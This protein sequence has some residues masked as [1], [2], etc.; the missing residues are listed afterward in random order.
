M[1]SA[2]YALSIPDIPTG[3]NGQQERAGAIRGDALEA[4]LRRIGLR[5]RPATDAEGLR[6]VHRAQHFAVP[7]ENLDLH[8][9]RPYALTPHHLARK[10]VA[11]RRGGF[12][13]ELN[14]LLAAALRGLGFE[15][16]ILEGQMRRR[17]G[18]FGPPFD[19]MTLRVVLPDGDWLADVG[20]GETFQRPLPWDGSWTPQERGGAWRVVRHADGQPAAEPRAASANAWRVEYR[21]REDAERETVYHFRSAP[22]RARDFGPMCVFH[23]T[24]ANSQFTKG[25]IVTRPLEGGGRVTAA[26]GL[27]MTTR[28]GAMERHAIRSASELEAILAERFGMR[29]VGIPPAWFTRGAR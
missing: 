5:A 14:L 19:H 1:T 17:E 2:R 22:V 9:G 24:S 8:L 18:G 20:N 16:E 21:A 13:Y 3:A 11:R 27:L 7:F 26:R 4:Y 15:V 12:C 25:W 10:M 28:D 29:P 23:T 6:A